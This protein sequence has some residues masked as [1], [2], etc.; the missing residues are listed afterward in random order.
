MFASVADAR[1][2][3]QKW[4]RVHDHAGDAPRFAHPDDARDSDVLM[5]ITEMDAGRQFV[6]KL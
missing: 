3:I 2:L 1:P 6:R 5:L 4:P